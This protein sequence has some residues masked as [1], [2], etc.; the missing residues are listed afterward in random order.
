MLIQIQL[1]IVSHLPLRSR[2]VFL[3]QVN[4]QFICLARHP[5]LWTEVN[6]QM[7]FQSN[8]SALSN[9]LMRY[10]PANSVEKLF[11]PSSTHSHEFLKFLITL[12]RLQSRLT[13]IHLSGKYVE[14]I[15]LAAMESLLGKWTN[16]IILDIPCSKIDI[17]HVTPLISAAPRLKIFALQ[18]CSKR[19]SLGGY[20]GFLRDLMRAGETTRLHHRH[21]EINARLRSL[22]VSCAS[23]QSVRFQNLAELGNFFPLLEMLRIENWRFLD[24][25]TTKVVPIKTLRGLSLVG[26]D[27]EKNGFVRT[28]LMFLKAFP[29]LEILF[30]G[31]RQ[32]EV[33]GWKLFVRKPELRGLFTEL[34]FPRL[35]CLW[36]RAWS[37]D[38]EDFMLLKADS[39]QWIVF[40][41][42][43]GMNG[44][45]KKIVGEKWN[46]AVVIESDTRFKQGIDFSTYRDIAK[47]KFAFAGV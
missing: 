20:D 16:T 7:P 10:T 31:A 4:K 29:A 32:M 41:E 46:G 21:P 25:N 18:T 45:W 33:L 13:T 22:Q 26:I 42:C 43:R 14:S 3:T 28:L 47:S 39:L 37:I 34:E 15:N 12:K 11:F 17:G 38:F 1:R 36:L 9:F 40:E 5:R 8:F 35:K 24:V 23:I 6:L 44:G 30:L 2:I 27:V 19:F